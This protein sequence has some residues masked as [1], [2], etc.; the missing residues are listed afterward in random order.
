MRSKI[1]MLLVRGAGRDNPKKLQKFIHKLSRDLK[2]TGIDPSIIH[3]EMVN[4]YGP[5]QE[6]QDRLMKL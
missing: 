3:F 4:W 6:N 5:T 1:G 2:K